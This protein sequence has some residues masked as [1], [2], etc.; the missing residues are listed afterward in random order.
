MLIMQTVWGIPEMPFLG[1]F[2]PP[3]VRRPF[4]VYGAD[5]A[6]LQID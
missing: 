2:A 6:Y 5:P 4:D 3:V 1:G